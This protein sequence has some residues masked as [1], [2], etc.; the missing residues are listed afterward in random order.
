MMNVS[1]ATVP[2]IDASI[3]VWGSILGMILFIAGLVLNIFVAYIFIT[4]KFFAQISYRLMLISV[5]SDIIS[6]IGQ[7]ISYAIK[8]FYFVNHYEGSM[9]CKIT[10]SIASISFG[11][12]IYNLYLIAF[13]RYYMI[14]HPH[15]S[16]YANN[17]YR[18]MTISEIIVWLM[19]GLL[20]INYFYIIGS[21]PEDT[22][23]CDF[24]DK[25]ISTSIYLIFKIMF[26]YVIPSIIIAVIY[27]RI[28]RHQNRYIRPGLATE[29]EL[30]IQIKRKRK[31]TRKLIF[32][33]FGFILTTWPSYVTFMYIAISRKSATTIRAENHLLYVFLSLIFLGSFSVTVVTPLLYLKFDENVRAR[34]WNLLKCQKVASVMRCRKNNVIHVAER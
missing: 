14:L 15:S 24:I 11:V 28:I 33:T 10:N 1:N 7:I 8:F 22:K 5:F 17:K 31:V 23:I 4:D 3:N 30:S 16:F 20:S 9:V 25:S 19:S 6:I 2:S 26:S 29:E 32:I 21:L 13:D 34:A 12:S 27:Y 18:I